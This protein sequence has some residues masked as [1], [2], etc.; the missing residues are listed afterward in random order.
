MKC[1]WFGKEWDNDTIDVTVLYNRLHDSK[2]V[3]FTVFWEKL[4]CGMGKKVRL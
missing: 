4:W 1:G 3:Y 2:N